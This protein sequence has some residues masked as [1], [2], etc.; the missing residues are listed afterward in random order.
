M[1]AKRRMEEAPRPPRP[2]HW[3][4]G[5]TPRQEAIFT[6]T[7]R[8]VRD[9]HQAPTTAEVVAG[10][11]DISPAA[12]RYNLNALVKA[13]YLVPISEGGITR[14]SPTGDRSVA[15]AKI[16]RLVDEGIA[17][18]SGGKPKGSRRGIKILGEGFVSDYVHQDRR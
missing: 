5:M 16:W 15:E 13:D 10:L 11:G 6:F 7:R 4:K 9:E 2:K 8:Y 12:V 3:D 17:T 14:W 1:V 18:W